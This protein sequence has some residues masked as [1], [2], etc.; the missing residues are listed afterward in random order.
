MVAASICAT[1]C[2]Q[3]HETSSARPH[4]QSPLPC[5]PPRPLRLI[6]REICSTTAGSTTGDRLLKG[7]AG[8]SYSSR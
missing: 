2:S 6:M 1:S 8:F 4:S 7:S 3:D 5:A